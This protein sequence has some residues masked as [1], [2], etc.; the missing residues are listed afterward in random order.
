MSVVN[1]P[2][3]SSQVAKDL[4]RLGFWFMVRIIVALMIAL[5]LR[6]DISWAGDDDEDSSPKAALQALNDFIGEWKGNGAPEK[7]RVERG[8]RW[9]E[10]GNWRWEI[11]GDEVWVKKAGENGRVLQEGGI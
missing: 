11:K 1:S 2:V 3:A 7:R 8:E 4:A 6:G 10:T 5:S 9:D